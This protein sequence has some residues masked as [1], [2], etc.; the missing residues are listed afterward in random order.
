MKLNIAEL[1]QERAAVLDKAAELLQAADDGKRDLTD[2]EER[3]FDR[4]H[5]EADTMQRKIAVAEHSAE[6]STPEY[7]LSMSTRSGSEADIVRRATT[8]PKPRAVRELALGL[9]VRGWFTGDRLARAKCCDLLGLDREQR[10]ALQD[11][12]G[13]GSAMVPEMVSSEVLRGEQPGV[14][15]PLCREFPMDSA[16]LV[17]PRLDGPPTV[18]IVAEE[19]QIGDAFGA[20]PIGGVTLTAKKLISM[21]TASNELLSD[22][23]VAIGAFLLDVLVEAVG[24][25]EDQQ[26]LEGDGTGQEF[27]GILAAS[28]TNE[29]VVD[30]APTC[31]DPFVE[32][33]ALLAAESPK[34]MAESTFVMSP[35][36]YGVIQALKHPGYSGD[37]IGK[38][39][40]TSDPTA[41]TP[42]SMLGRPIVLCNQIVDNSGTGTNEST[43]YLGAFKRGMAFGNR[44]AVSVYRDPFSMLDTFQTRIVIGER[45]G[46]A[47]GLP[48]AFVKITGVEVST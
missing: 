14:I 9:A 16:T 41:A 28:N 26:A 8:E 10:A 11:A 25:M 37:V 47:V 32:A 3:E 35:V 36:A 15:R 17:I 23:A 2:N 40:V 34:Y 44:N 45:V 42:L 24:Q 19:G 27:T 29:V 39:M 31:L 33:L 7:P 5:R 12:A 43:V 21:V 4:L 48:S 1:R 46:I 38:Y 30:A 6:T 18:A 22:S 13:E 20:S